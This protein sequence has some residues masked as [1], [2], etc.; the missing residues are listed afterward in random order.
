MSEIIEQAVAEA[1]PASFEDSKPVETTAPAE[2]PVVTG[3]FHTPAETVSGTNSSGVE[4]EKPVEKEA[5]QVD[6]ETTEQV[7]GDVTADLL[8]GERPSRVETVAETTPKETSPVDGGEAKPAS[9]PPTPEQLAQVE[10]AAA[11][12]AEEVPVEEGIKEEIQAVPED[13]PAQDVT[14]AVAETAAEEALAAAV[15]A[16]VVTPEVAADSVA[17][18][19]DNERKSNASSATKKSLSDKD[20][21]SQDKKAA[22]KTRVSSPPTNGRLPN[23]KTVTN[24][25]SLKPL[26]A[27]KEVKQVKVEEKKPEVKKESSS[28]KPKPA[29]KKPEKRERSSDARKNSKKSDITNASK[30][31]NEGTP[32]ILTPADSLDSEGR[33][34]STKKSEIDLAPVVEKPKV[35]VVIRKS[36]IPPIEKGEGVLARKSNMLF[37]KKSTR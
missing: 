10:A 1:P 11:P 17:K 37:P 13:A 12:V 4:G 16:V 36:T 8:A 6:A 5:N 7:A 26:P 30:T 18:G 34:K 20:P 9:K 25:A 19:L 22:A 27:K 23:D 21:K 33:E 3:E 2:E 14:E 28:L 15:P 35:S 31:T 32:Q 24:K 29:P